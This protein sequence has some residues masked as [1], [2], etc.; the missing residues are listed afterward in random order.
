MTDPVTPTEAPDEGLPA[1]EDIEDGA[2][3]DERP[4]EPVDSPRPDL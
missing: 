1:D 4:D 3:M 2:S